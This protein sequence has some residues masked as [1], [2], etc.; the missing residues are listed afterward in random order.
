MLT[1]VPK[2]RLIYPHPLKTTRFRPTALQFHPSVAR[3]F[4]GWC[5]PCLAICLH[6]VC[7]LA[8]ERLPGR[9][10]PLAPLPPKDSLGSGVSL[11][12]ASVKAEAEASSDDPEWLFHLRALVQS[13][14][15]QASRRAFDLF[16]LGRLERPLTL[17]LTLLLKVTFRVSSGCILLRSRCS[18]WASAFSVI[19]LKD[20]P[21]DD[22]F[23]ETAPQTSLLFYFVLFP[24]IIVRCHWAVVGRGRRLSAIWRC[25]LLH[26]WLLR[27]EVRAGV[28]QR[29]PWH[30]GR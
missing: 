24:I 14:D 19:V 6:L 20:F 18:R 4:L 2:L 13:C 3:A 5:H 11:R 28:S 23:L 8:S 29:S 15:H 12:S 27:W 9:A 21:E 1:A 7:Q 22:L 30:P 10:M 16:L 26:V 25:P 17:G